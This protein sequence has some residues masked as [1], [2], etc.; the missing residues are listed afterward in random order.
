MEPLADSMAS[1]PAIPSSVAS[2]LASKTGGLYFACLSELSPAA[3]ELPHSNSAQPSQQSSMLNMV[4]SS[5]P[6]GLMC[7]STATMSLTTSALFQLP[8]PSSCTRDQASW[9]WKGGMQAWLRTAASEAGKEHAVRK[10]GCKYM[11]SLPCVR[12][13]GWPSA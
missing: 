5:R 8:L 4:S 1:L 11:G 13:V 10:L 3:E 12:A 9:L 6:L 2:P 7:A